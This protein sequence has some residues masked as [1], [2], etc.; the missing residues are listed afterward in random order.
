MTNTTSSKIWA[1]CLAGLTFLG[2]AT[3]VGI[4]SVEIETTNAAA[5]KEPAPAQRY[6]P[7]QLANYKATLD[8]EAAR[9]KIYRDDL[10]QLAQQL[11]KEGAR[12]NLSKQSNARALRELS[13]ESP[14][15]GPS[16]G[17][18]GDLL[19]A[20]APEIIRPE[21]APATDGNTYSS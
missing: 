5:E 12:L 3:A 7:E 8:K 9:L 14:F 11:K 16:Q 18:S 2:I 21:P 13:K 15:S 19:P 20:P 17:G 6:S 10:A 1:T 4:K